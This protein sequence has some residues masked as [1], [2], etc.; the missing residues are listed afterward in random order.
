MEYFRI[1]LP[2]I[3][4]GTYRLLHTM[5]FFLN[6]FVNI[7]GFFLSF[8][9][10]LLVVS[11]RDLQLNGIPMRFNSEDDIFP[12]ACSFCMQF[13]LISLLASFKSERVLQFFFLGDSSLVE[14]PNSFPNC[15][16]PPNVI[17][18]SLITLNFFRKD[19]FCASSRKRIEF[20]WIV[21]DGKSTFQL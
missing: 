14:P 20:W 2:A 16:R 21:V 7:F 10:L 11:W 5:R 9:L 3:F 8:W 6:K 1:I 19:W 15:P 4:N 17:I 13:K 12:F 18:L